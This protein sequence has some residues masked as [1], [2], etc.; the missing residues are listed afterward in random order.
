MSPKPSLLHTGLIL[1][2]SFVVIGAVWL[3]LSP[4]YDGLLAPAA[5]AFLPAV[6]WLEDSGGTMVIHHAADGQHYGHAFDTLVL[7]SGLVIVLALVAATP[8]RSWPWRTV[9]GGSV[10]GGFFALQAAAMVAVAQA[11]KSSVSGGLQAGDVWV[12]F[13]IFWA[14]TPLAIGGAWVYRFWMPAMRHG[15]CEAPNATARHSEAAS[16]D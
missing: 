16:G 1:T 11:L 8:G 14:L 3:R 12:G 9:A 6:L 2:W 5:N 7:H 15:P 4:F 13:A 10:I